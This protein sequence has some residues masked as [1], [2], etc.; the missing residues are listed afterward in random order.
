VWPKAVAS[1]DRPWVSTWAAFT[2]AA[3][4]WAA[5]PLIDLRLF[6]DRAFAAASDGLFLLG[7][8]LFGALLLPPLYYRQA[9]GQGALGAGLLLVP[10]GAGV[11]VALKAAG[12]LTDR[13]GPRIA[14]LCIHVADG[15]GE[16]PPPQ[17]DGINMVAGEQ[18][19]PPGKRFPR[20]AS[21]IS[22]VR[23]MSLA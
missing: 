9:H 17:V 22:P 16:L 12:R 11:A 10:Q 7:M 23:V 6:A 13:R 18:A 1:A 5:R 4:A 20:S 2:P 3:C 21:A 8:A 14:V 19:E 15:A